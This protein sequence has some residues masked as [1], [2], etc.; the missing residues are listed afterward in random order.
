MLERNEE[1]NKS[2]PSKNDDQ[3]NKDYQCQFNHNQDKLDSS[4]HEETKEKE[5]GK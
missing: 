4:V 3:V 1:H 5:I 2:Q